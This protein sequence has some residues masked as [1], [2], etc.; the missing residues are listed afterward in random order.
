MT[1]RDLATHSLHAGDDEV[2][3]SYGNARPGWDDDEG[4]PYDDDDDD[5]SY[6]DDDDEDDLDDDEDDE[7]DNVLEV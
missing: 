5:D 6:A 4:D 3:P 7:L 1:M 2:L